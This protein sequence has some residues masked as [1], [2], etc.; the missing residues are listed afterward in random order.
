MDGHSSQSASST[1]PA[2]PPSLKA[3]ADTPR[4]ALGAKD[5]SRGSIADVLKRTPMELPRRLVVSRTA[6]PIMRKCRPWER[7]FAPGCGSL[8]LSETQGRLPGR[9]WE[10]WCR[11]VRGVVAQ[12]RTCGAGSALP[13]CFMPQAHARLCSPCPHRAHMTLRGD[14]SRVTTSG[15]WRGWMCHT[16]RRQRA[17]VQVPQ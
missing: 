8:G 10:G 7:S 3:L 2:A 12:W 16:A 5:S 17:Y 11:C 4:Q 13:S 6:Y 15:T 9:A 1:T 14:W